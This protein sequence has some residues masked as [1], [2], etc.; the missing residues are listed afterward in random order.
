MTLAISCNPSSSAHTSAGELQEQSGAPVFIRDAVI[1]Q[2]LNAVTLTFTERTK[3]D[4]NLLAVMVQFFKSSPNGP[5]LIEQTVS[6]KW[7]TEEIGK[8][9]P[10]SPQLQISGLT[11]FTTMTVELYYDSKHI[12]KKTFE[13]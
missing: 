8:K 5:L 2:S 3:Y 9:S 12:G 10:N 13:F 1:N 11:R 7:L 4:P 6:Y